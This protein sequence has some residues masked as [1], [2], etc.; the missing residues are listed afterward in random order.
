MTRAGKADG[1]DR[2]E[3]AFAYFRAEGGFRNTRL[4]EAPNGDFAFSMARLLVF[5]AH[6]LALLDRLTDS[7]DPVLA[8]VAAKGVKEV[9]YHRDYAAGWVVRLGDGTSLSHQRMQDGLAALWPLVDEL[10]QPH[11]VEHRLACAG[12]GVDPS[13]LRAEF[14]A[15]LAQILDKATLNRP[16]VDPAQAGGRDGQHSEALGTLLTEMQSVARAH[17]EA[18]W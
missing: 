3:D 2:D 11:P 17:P 9:T 7:R 14:D 13:T 1:T 18:T 12:V 6:R 10:F 15:V 4:V 5:S 8:A 16:T